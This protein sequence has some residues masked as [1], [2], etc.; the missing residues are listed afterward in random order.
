LFVILL[1]F[2]ASTAAATPIPTRPPDLDLAALISVAEKLESFQPRDAFDDEP[3]TGSVAGKSFAYEIA[4]HPYREGSIACNGEPEW[5]YDRQTARLTVNSNVGFVLKE[6]YRPTTVHTLAPTRFGYTYYAFRCIHKSLESYE[7]TNA[8]G[9]KITVATYQDRTLAVATDMAIDDD[10]QSSWEASLAS[11]DARALVPHLRVRIRGV[12]AD[13]SPGVAVVCGSSDLSP[14]IDR[15]IENRVD[16]CLYKGKIQ[17]FE[18]IDGRNVN[19][20]YA[21]TIHR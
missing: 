12:L 17:Q 3:E 15:P 13:W 14:T 10:W 21:S 7:A 2:A 1:L 9:A 8:L 18:V 19:V 4:P 20:L 11:E 6:S 5:S 16:L